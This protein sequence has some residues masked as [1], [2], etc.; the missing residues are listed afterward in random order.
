MKSGV[1]GAHV[2]LIILVIWLFSSMKLN[3]IIDNIKGRHYSDDNS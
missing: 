2:Y 3:N 1:Q